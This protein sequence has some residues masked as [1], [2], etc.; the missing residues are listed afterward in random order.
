M[1]L[2]IDRRSA[3]ERFR[4]VF[5]HLGTITAYAR[6]RGSKDADALAA[7][8]MTVAWRRLADVP[9]GDPLPW[10]YGT[11][12]NL[13]LA[14]RRLSA[15]AARTSMR[16]PE[17]VASAPEPHE[18]D[19]DLT[20]ALRSLS[21]IDREALLL[22]AWEDLAPSQAAKAL[23]INPAAFRVRLL[24]ARRRLRAS[25]DLPADGRPPA[26]LSQLDVEGT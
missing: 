14:E 16:E 10:L 12:R 18:L 1:A 19:P 11:A 24:R 22:V 13:V 5:A 21:E 8:V 23:G 9:P 20:R 25:L 17:R 3:E 15:P 4:T 7:E 6:R 26:A 2:E